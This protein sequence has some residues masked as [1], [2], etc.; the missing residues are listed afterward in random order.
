ME[1]GST[2]MV[3]QLLTTVKTDMLAEVGAALPIAGAVF[4]AIAGVMIGVKLFK[5]ITGARA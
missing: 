4:A 5:R 3:T 2:S 1:G